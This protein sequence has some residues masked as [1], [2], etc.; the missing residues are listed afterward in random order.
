MRNPFEARWAN[1]FM[2]VAEAVRDLSYSEIEKVGA[3]VVDGNTLQISAF[4]YNAL[5]QGSV[6]LMEQKDS[7]GNLVP[8]P[9]IIS[10]V[11]N[12]LLRSRMSSAY[13]F[14][15]VLF[16]TK[17]P[18]VQDVVLIA[19][20]NIRYVVVPDLNGDPDGLLKLDD[21]NI[22]VYSLSQ[23]K[24]NVSDDEKIRAHLAGLMK[25][26]DEGDTQAEPNDDNM[27]EPK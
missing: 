24:D 25:S 20:T 16:T 23:L 7:D 9:D 27:N 13:G 22:T 3:V 5:P 4:G 2:R 10:A 17:M 12:A 19:N 18:S 11:Q 8:V 15:D 14:G 21:Y 1:F 26:K 6:N